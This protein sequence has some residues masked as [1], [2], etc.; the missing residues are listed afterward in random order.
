M[1]KM[2]KHETICDVARSVLPLLARQTCRGAGLQPVVMKL[3]LLDRQHM[4]LP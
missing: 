2:R 4:R 1:F 3:S